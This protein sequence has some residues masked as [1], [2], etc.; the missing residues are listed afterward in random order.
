MP[1]VLANIMSLRGDGQKLREE[2]EE[3]KTGR[4]KIWQV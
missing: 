4:G 1:S 2:K 3:E